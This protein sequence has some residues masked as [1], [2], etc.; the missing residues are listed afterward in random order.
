M[1]LRGVHTVGSTTVTSTVL[2]ALRGDPR[3]RAEFF[4]LTGA[5]LTSVGS[6]TV[7]RRWPSLRRRIPSDDPVGH[8][9]LQCAQKSVQVGNQDSLRGSDELRILTAGHLRTMVLTSQYHT[10]KYLSLG[11]RIGPRTGAA[12]RSLVPT[13]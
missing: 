4:A 10:H 5:T 11:S 7:F 9:G 3:S 6:V 2:G 8:L 1:T 12:S 13:S